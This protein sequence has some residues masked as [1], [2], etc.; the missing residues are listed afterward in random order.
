MKKKIVFAGFRH[1]HILGLY[2][3]AAASAKL[4]IVGA[5]EEDAQ[6]VENL[7][8]TN[9]TLTIT[10]TSFDA[11]LAGTPCDIVAI[12]DYYAKR[13]SLAIRALKAGKHVVADKPLCTSLEELSEIEQLASKTGLKIGCMLDLR[14]GDTFA[15]A[16]EFVR[17]GKLGKVTQIQFG[18]QHPLLRA[19]R[20]GWYF[21]NGKHGGT[22]NDIAIHA[23]DYIPWLTGSDFKSFLAARTWKAFDMENDGFNDAAQ[24]MLE[25][26]NGC[27]ILGD[28]SYAVPDS[29]GYKNPQYWRFTV[30]G[31][32]GIIEFNCIEKNITAYINGE[33]EPQTIVPAPYAGPNYL[34]SFLSDIEGAA[35][36][37]NTAVVLKRTRQA[38][39]LQKLA[40]SNAR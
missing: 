17:S 40:D 35:P 2:N 14:T 16:Q 24:F 4:E 19:T 9:P 33:K 12:G 21:E 3:A 28:V 11:M 39:E 38:L 18:G 7:K 37:L 31:T 22:I 25:L 6:T 36:E 30:W 20:P 10:N 8:K 34:D 13:G 27:G 1:G 23:I 26:D 15:T 32:K 29:L 5:C